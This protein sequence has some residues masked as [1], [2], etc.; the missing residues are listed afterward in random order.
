MINN[1]KGKI[2]E[3]DDVSTTMISAPATSKPITNPLSGKAINSD[4]SEEQD[5]SEHGNLDLQP[6]SSGDG[7]VQDGIQSKRQKTEAA[8]ADND[9]R[10]DA[11]RRTIYQ[12]KNASATK[13]GSADAKA[14]FQQS[15]TVE[16]NETEK[17]QKMP[18]AEA[19]KLQMK[20]FNK[21]EKFARMSKLE[22]ALGI[23]EEHLNSWLNA[24][25][26]EQ[27]EDEIPH[28]MP[29]FTTGWSNMM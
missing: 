7:K 20:V 9:A 19:L 6:S 8:L 4:M 29:Q 23:K 2:T 15:M 16:M 24:W 10:F 1:Y 25:E 18:K 12:G 27:V 26:G 3:L 14:Q 22:K 11:L 17:K 5:E 21:L 28:D 13:N